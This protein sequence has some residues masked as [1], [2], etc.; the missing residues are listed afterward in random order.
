MYTLFSRVPRF[1]GPFDTRGRPPNIWRHY[2]NNESAENGVGGYYA[3]GLRRNYHGGVHLFPDNRAANT[4]VRAMAPGF[5]VAARLPGKGSTALHA[6][7]LQSVGNWPGFVLVRHEL[8]ELKAEGEKGSRGTFYSLYMHLRSPLF[9]SE[10]DSRKSGIAPPAVLD[11]KDPYLEV[12]WFLS[13]AERRYGAFVHT[14]DERPPAATPGKKAPATNAVQPLGQLF[15]AAEKVE[16]KSDATTKNEYQVTDANVKTIKVS[17]RDAESSTTGAA[18]PGVDWVY[19]PSPGELI[20][21]VDELAWGSVVTFTEPF[22]PVK[23]GEV[24]GFVGPLSKDVDLSKLTIPAHLRNANGRVA[25]D[26]HGAAL[27]QKLTLGSGFLHWQVFAPK[28]GE[29]GVELLVKLA[30]EVTKGVTVDSSLPQPQPP[31]FSAISDTNNDCFISIGELRSQLKPALPE[32][33]REAFETAI[34]DVEEDVK[35]DFSY[36]RAVIEMLDGATSFAPAQTDVDWN[37]GCK[38]K[39][40]LL[41]QLEEQFLVPPNENSRTRGKYT[42]TFSFSRLIGDQVV[43]LACGPLCDRSVCSPTARGPGPCTPKPF[44][45]DPELFRKRRDAEE[46]LVT[47]KL[48]VP[49]DADR[50]TIDFGPGL[51]GEAMEPPVGSDLILLKDALASRWRGSTIKHLNEWS[52]DSVESIADKLKDHIELTT[53]AKEFAWCDPEKEVT[54]ERNEL[55]N[56]AVHYAKKKVEAAVQFFAGKDSL[57]PANGT[58]EDLHPTTAVWLLNLLDRHKKA[59]LVE[60]ISAKAFRKEDAA[61][62]SVAWVTNSNEPK[63]EVGGHVNVLVI[64][65]DFGEEGKSTISVIAEGHGRLELASL[66]YQHGGVALASVSVCFWGDW[67]V[68]TWP[69]PKGKAK[70][71]FQTLSIQPLAFETLSTEEIGSH[72][73]APVKAGDGKLGWLIKV[74]SPVRAVEGFV[75]MQSRK[76][77]GQWPAPS[78][79]EDAVVAATARPVLEVPTEDGKGVPKDAAALDV[80]D[81]FIVGLKDPKGKDASVSPGFKLSDFRLA[82]TDILVACPLLDAL[83]Q[84]RA[85][86]SELQLSI[87]SIASDGVSMVVRPTVAPAATPAG[88]PSKLVAACEA[89]AKEV[90]KTTRLAVR[91]ANDKLGRVELSVG[92]TI[93]H[94]TSCP[95]LATYASV[96]RTSSSGDFILD[97]SGSLGKFTPTNLRTAYAGSGFRLAVTL[98]RALEYLLSKIGKFAVVWLSRDG[99]GCRI[100][101]RTPAAATFV[102]DCG[103]FSSTSV[104]KDGLTMTVSPDAQRFMSVQ[105]ETGPLVAALTKRADIKPGEQLQYRFFFET[106]NGLKYLVGDDGASWPT[107]ERAPLTPQIIESLASRRPKPERPSYGPSAPAADL[108]SKVTIDGLVLTWMT[109]KGVAGIEARFFCLGLPADWANL[110]VKVSVATTGAFATVPGAGSLKRPQDD[111]V[112]VVQVPVP[113]SK[114]YTGNV[115]IR[116]EVQMKGK[117]FDQ[118]T[119]IERSLDCEPKWLQGNLTL[120]DTAPEVLVIRCRGQGF[121][122]PEVVNSTESP[123]GSSREFVLEVEDVTVE[124][125]QGN[126]RPRAPALPTV[127]YALPGSHTGFL[128]GAG[129]EAGL[130]EAR[131]AKVAG[132]ARAA[133]IPMVVGRTYKLSLARPRSDGPTRR[134]VRGKPLA[135]ISQT[136]T[137]RG[138]AVTPTVP[139]AASGPGARK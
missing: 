104:E 96:L 110:T 108:F 59:A 6:D 46:K 82:A 71:G 76:P 17:S 1:G 44:V 4:P 69:S 91:P 62:L 98:A 14:V 72:L 2:A 67:R 130:F 56:A 36:A 92:G 18:T 131:L 26:G 106:L 132:T 84:I 24:L 134:P 15:W 5:I 100:N 13:L 87:D 30:K 88:T 47:F 99:L 127:T 29:N 85:R 97:A 51:A 83:L 95:A 77:D 20:K 12:P 113:D 122:L 105:F 66:P 25:T 112:L 119:P 27:A 135:P 70:F 86:V 116:V 50:M 49:A 63:P 107:D 19:K 52:V 74:K 102:R 115:R 114:D 33:D 41:L 53:L 90:A 93:A 81:G 42:L 32:A 133:P 137:F 117:A 89:V 129:P 43:P 68:G 78:S 94:L 38:L 58:I 3:V 11:P 73:N 139:G 23:A 125:A 128:K 21:A 48:M 65:D 8:E 54:I 123:V 80:R 64:D 75:T 118:V 121:E 136:Y 103:L 31:V 109:S 34:K 138:P 9:K 124:A 10:S 120:D 22:L 126:T 37:P 55:E 16:I 45:I 79:R 28:K 40:P 39:Y 60:S 111:A 101:S 35:T 7:V 61:P 57:L